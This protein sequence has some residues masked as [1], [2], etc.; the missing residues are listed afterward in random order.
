MPYLTSKVDA[1]VA[2]F[3]IAG[4]YLYVRD[5][6]ILGYAAIII[7]A[8]IKIYPIIFIIVFLVADAY[9]SPLGK[10]IRNIS[11]GG[12]TCILTVAA[13][14]IPLLL[15]H[16]SFQELSEWWSTYNARGFQVESTVAV[17]I[18]FFGNLGLWDYALVDSMDTK[19]VVSGITDR[20]VQGWIFVVIAL[21]AFIILCIVHHAR[22]NRT[23]SPS[24][25]NM[26]LYMGAIVLM[27]VL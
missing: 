5:R 6:R 20:L 2:F 16:A 12:V 22:N 3:V 15:M 24:L 18:E 17:F 21:M 1:I 23:E 11:I 13:I 10:R 27:L 9:A 7:A 8:S 4:M 19:D 25:G 26:S 14:F